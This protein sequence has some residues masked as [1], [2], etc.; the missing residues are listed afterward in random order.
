MMQDQSVA[1]PVTDDRLGIQKCIPDLLVNHVIRKESAQ[2][3][4][5]E[6]HEFIRDLLEHPLGVE[7]VGKVPGVVGISMQVERQHLGWVEANWVVNSNQKSLIRSGD[8]H[9]M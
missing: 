4:R 3:R 1:D 9:L 7:D 2:I 8:Q 5:L 6:R